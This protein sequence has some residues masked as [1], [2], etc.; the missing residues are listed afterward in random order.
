MAL[1]KICQAATKSGFYQHWQPA[2]SEF[3]I[4]AERESRGKPAEISTYCLVIGGSMIFTYLSAAVGR[5]CASRIGA[6]LV[7]GI[8]FLGRGIILKSEM[9]RKNGKR[10]PPAI[11]KCCT[12]S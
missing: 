10:C 12:P 9:D 7:T 4:E 11:R 2:S 8:R 5:N 6:Q 3:F 1:E